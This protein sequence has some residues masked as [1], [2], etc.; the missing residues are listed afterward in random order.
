M[1]LVILPHCHYE[2]IQRNMQWRLTEEFYFMKWIDIQLTIIVKNKEKLS[3]FILEPKNIEITL[4]M[5]ILQKKWRK[6]E[7]ERENCFVFPPNLVQLN[8]LCNALLGSLSTQIFYLACCFS[9]QLGPTEC[10]LQ[11]TAW[12]IVKSNLLFSMPNWSEF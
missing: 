9:P 4:T 7:R 8:A 6:R 3:Y 11:H 5:E 2:L 1:I 10:S 12:L